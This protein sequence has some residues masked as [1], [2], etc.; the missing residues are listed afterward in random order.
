MDDFVMQSLA[1]VLGIVLLIAFFMLVSRVGQ[2]LA[3]V[4]NLEQQAAEQ[5]RYLGAISMNV[6]VAQRSKESKGAS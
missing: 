6:A 2:I 4:R 1:S 5:T 3:A